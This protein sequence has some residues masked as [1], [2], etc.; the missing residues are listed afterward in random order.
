VPRP[1]TDPGTI[2]VWSDLGCPWSHVVVWRLWDARRR[3]GVE[4]R[5]RFDHRAFP[6]ELF[7]DEPTP[8]W[9]VDVEAP[10]AEALA[11]RAG[12]R[13]WSAPDSTWPVT[14]LLPLEAVQAA[15]LQSLAAAE[16]LD[17]G[18]R[19]ALFGE[20][21]CI[22]LRHVVLEVAS[23]ADGVDVAM[24]AQALDDGRARHA[25]IADWRIAQGDEIRGS[26]HV[27]LADGTNAQNPGIGVGWEDDGSA[28]GRY[29]I[30]HDDPSA[31]EALVRR[32]AD[33]T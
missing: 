13:A 30:D 28:A 32:A 11:P 33:L 17:R 16:T 14:L 7:N 29:W 18:L 9:H 20:S 2:Q 19:R 23:E 4:D 12:W 1:P 26:A 22:S 8:R 3:L 21:R 31:I 6:L 25:L 24:L 27:F 5:L 15:K 10:V